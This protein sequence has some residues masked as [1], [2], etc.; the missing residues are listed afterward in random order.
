MR[1]IIF[2]TKK[3]KF[4]KVQKSY[5][6]NH[7]NKNDWMYVDVVKD[8]ENLRIASSV[9]IDKLPT[10]VIL[11][12]KNQEIH[13]KEGT[14][15]PDQ[16]FQIMEGDGKIPIFKED[17]KGTVTLS[18]D[19]D[20]FRGAIVKAYKLNGEYLYDVK[21]KSCRK[22]QTKNMEVNSVN[23]KNYMNRGGRKDFC[24]KVIFTQVGGK[25]E[26]K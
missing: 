14:L 25:E 20:I 24:W 23:R 16:I 15:P 6:E 13:R 3:C 22:I 10:V 26:V 8:M 1:I 4:C 5:L 2:G 17:K 12:E 18:Y 11:N 19:P 9:N 21:I 7:F